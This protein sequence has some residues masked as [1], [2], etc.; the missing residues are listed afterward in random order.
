MTV[1]GSGGAALFLEWMKCAG[2]LWCPFEQVDLSK[3]TAYGVYVIWKPSGTRQP[4]TV[5]RV[6]RGDIAKRLADERQDTLLRTR[7]PGLLFTWATV[8]RSFAPGVEAFLSAQLQPL[9]GGATA[10]TIPYE[11]NLPGLA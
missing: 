7:G 5:I 4:S 2:G 11:V 3:V 8:D 9:A 10:L 6:G 1:S